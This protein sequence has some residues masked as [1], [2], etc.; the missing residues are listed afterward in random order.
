VNKIDLAFPNGENFIPVSNFAT[1]SGVSIKGTIKPTEKENKGKGFLKLK[2]ETPITNTTNKINIEGIRDAFVKVWTRIF[3]NY[4]SFLTKTITPD[5]TRRQTVTQQPQQQLGGDGRPSELF[6]KTNF[7]QQAGEELTPFVT[8]MLQTQT[9]GLFID[10]RWTKDG[11]S[12]PTDDLEIKLF[13][14]LIIVKQSKNK[15]Q[16]KKKKTTPFLEDK[17]SDISETFVVP[18]PSTLDLR[19]AVYEYN[20]F[21][22]LQD[23][24]FGKIR[25]VKP[26]IEDN[27]NFKQPKK[28][29]EIL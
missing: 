20:S 24:L 6:E 18:P 22:K 2:K 15:L 10:Q 11:K 26:L 1:D 23:S 14:E 8:E 19:P 17:S 28:K 27:K 5:S 29:N 16:S 7:I 21:P 13:D 25:F 3:A 12:T 4:R 9:F